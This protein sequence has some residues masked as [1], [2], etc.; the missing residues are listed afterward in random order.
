MR[1][2]QHGIESTSNLLAEIWDLLLREIKNSS[3]LSFFKKKKKKKKKKK[4]ESLKK[5]YESFVRHYKKRLAV[6]F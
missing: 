3:A 4:N 6:V 1:T 2:T 5:I